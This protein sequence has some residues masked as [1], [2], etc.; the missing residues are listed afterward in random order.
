MSHKAK[1]PNSF[2]GGSH[3][4]STFT[5][6]Y[7]TF[8]RDSEPYKPINDDVQYRSKTSNKWS[9]NNPNKKGFYGTFTEFPKH[10]EEG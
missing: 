3:P 4:A 9:Y 8:Y 7:Q 6:H 1:I 2:A 10:I 5:P